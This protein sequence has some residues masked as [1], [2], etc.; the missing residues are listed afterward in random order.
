M[1]RIDLRTVVGRASAGRDHSRQ[2]SVKV[3]AVVYFRI[4]DPPRR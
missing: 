1:V 3:N 2:R 4:L